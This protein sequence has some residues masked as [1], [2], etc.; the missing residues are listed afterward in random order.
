MQ[1]EISLPYFLQQH[2]ITKTQLTNF[3][4]TPNAAEILQM[5]MNPYRM[6]G[7]SISSNKPLIIFTRTDSKYPVEE[8]FNAVT[9]N[10]IVNI[11]LEPVNTLLHQNWLHR[12]TVLIQTSLAGAAQKWFPVSPIDINSDW[13]RF[14]QGFS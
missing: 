13:K 7:S 11:G 1:N 5:T 8:Y 12:R 3:S 14:K 10:L 6:G 4:Q 9:A 2:E